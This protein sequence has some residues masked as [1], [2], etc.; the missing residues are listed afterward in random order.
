MPYLNPSSYLPPSLPWQGKRAQETGD[1]L[2]LQRTGVHLK[3]EEQQSQLE[4]QHKLFSCTLVMKMAFVKMDL[5][6]VSLLISFNLNQMKMFFASKKEQL[7]FHKLKC[8]PP[9]I[10]K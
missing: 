2:V 5:Q 8:P 9:H 10:F 4:L 3:T 6:S 7:K 1:P